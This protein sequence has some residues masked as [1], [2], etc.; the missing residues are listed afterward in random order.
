MV[1]KHFVVSYKCYLITIVDYLIV[2][3]VYSENKDTPF[4]C[5]HNNFVSVICLEYGHIF[6]ALHGVFL[7]ASLTGQ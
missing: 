1:T 2:Q 3:S 4:N 5:L 6:L 7:R